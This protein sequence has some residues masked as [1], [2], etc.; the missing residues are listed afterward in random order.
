MNR[1]PNLI[2]FSGVLAV[3]IIVSIV[4]GIAVNI[5]T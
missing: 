5:L 3:L 2:I 4:A 1:D